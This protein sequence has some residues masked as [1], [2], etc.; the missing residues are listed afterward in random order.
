MEADGDAEEAVLSVEGVAEVLAEGEEGFLGGKCP[1]AVELHL[2]DGGQVVSGGHGVNAGEDFVGVLLLVA[3]HAAHGVDGDV[4]DGDDIKGVGDGLVE[5]GG[6]DGDGSEPEGE[7]S[8]V[9]GDIEEA[10]V[11]AT[12]VVTAEEGPLGGVGVEGGF[13][14]VDGVA[15]G[16]DREGGFGCGQSRN[17][18]FYPGGVGCA[19]ACRGKREGGGDD[20]GDSGWF[21]F[22]KYL[23]VV[24]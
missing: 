9:H 24:G 16:R 14:T 2:A 1:V 7:V 6:G 15:S 8:V 13:P 4:D 19:S 23:D 18:L 5:Y 22:R 10:E 17:S 21:H 20:D 3:G 12:D 11:E